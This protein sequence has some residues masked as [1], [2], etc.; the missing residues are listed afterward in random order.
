VSNPKQTLE[1][2]SNSARMTFGRVIDMLVDG[3]LKE[4]DDVANEAD[5][6]EKIKRFGELTELL[7]QKYRT[8][9]KMR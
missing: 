9:D 3:K 5:D 6:L 1:D 4:I 2:I 7:N 8:L